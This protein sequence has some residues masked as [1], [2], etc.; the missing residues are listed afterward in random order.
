MNTLR[1]SLIAM[2]ALLSGCAT[3]TSTNS[4]SSGNQPGSAFYGKVVGENGRALRAGVEVEIYDA[5]AE[6]TAGPD[7]TYSYKTDRNGRFSFAKRGESMTIKISKSGYTD[8][9]GQPEASIRF[10]WDNNRNG[11]AVSTSKR[12]PFVIVL[13]KK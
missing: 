2:L 9:Y 12:V 7:R 1:F 13:K 4:S 5:N 11:W 8:P 10:S 6:L 3:T